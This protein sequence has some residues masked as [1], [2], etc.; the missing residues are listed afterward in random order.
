MKYTYQP[1][2]SKKQAIIEII[3]ET[4][5]EQL[6]FSGMD[7]DNIDQ[8]TLYHYYCKG[9]EGNNKY[10]ALLSI[11]IFLIFPTKAIISYDIAKGI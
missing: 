1:L 7:K 2:S 9:L 3:P 4:E 8:D 10:A 5:K 11:D 6:L